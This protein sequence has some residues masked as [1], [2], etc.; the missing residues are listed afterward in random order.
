MRREIIEQTFKFG[1]TISLKLLGQHISYRV[2]KTDYV[3]TWLTFYV[4]K[5]SVF[6]GNIKW[7]AHG[8]ILTEISETLHFSNRV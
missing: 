3:Q 7:K 2:E 4:L 5:I 6:A 8:S 1:K